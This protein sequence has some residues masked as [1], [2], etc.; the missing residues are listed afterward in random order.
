MNKH[1]DAEYENTE[2]FSRKIDVSRETQQNLPKKQR[3]VIR[4]T[5][6]AVCIK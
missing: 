5:K 3:L 1:S 2:Q 4:K 6:N